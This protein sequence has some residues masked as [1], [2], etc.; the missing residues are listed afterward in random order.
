MK[1]F[2]IFIILIL[3]FLP[4]KSKELN[5]CEWKNKSGTPC[6]TIFSAPNTSEITEETLGKTVIT[7]QQMIEL[8]MTMLE[9]Y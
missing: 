9:A 5:N 8:D 7:K 4:V 6:I 2:F 3:S 1:I